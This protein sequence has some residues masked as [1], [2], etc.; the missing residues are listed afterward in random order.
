MANYLGGDS[1]L[2]LLPLG[3]L[4]SIPD[5]WLM[6]V[7]MVQPRRDPRAAVTH[8]GESFLLQ[9]QKGTNMWLHK[10]VLGPAAKQYYYDWMRGWVVGR[11]GDPQDFRRG[12]RRRARR[13]TPR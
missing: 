13:R 2:L 7:T 11:R 1:A 5:R 12:G 9:L 8:G 6:F 10:P 3:R 4:G